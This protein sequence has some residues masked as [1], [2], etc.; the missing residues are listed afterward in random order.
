LSLWLLETEVS[1]RVV[2]ALLVNVD[3]LPFIRR[4]S[5]FVFESILDSL[6][7][8][9]PVF[10]SHIHPLPGGRKKIFSFRWEIAY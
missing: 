8:S 4:F 3:E 2:I 1:T 10:L 6:S 9:V 5:R 7:H